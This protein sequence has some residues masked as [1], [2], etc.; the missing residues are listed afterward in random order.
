MSVTGFNPCFLG[1][2]S[3]WPYSFAVWQILLQFQSLF[4]W[5]DLCVTRRWDAYLLSMYCFNP[6][7]LG[8]TSACGSCGTS[9]AERDSRRVSILVFLDRPLRA[10]A[11]RGD[12]LD[13][14]QFQSLFSWIDLCVTKPINGNSSISAGSKVSILVFLDR[15]LRV[16][17]SVLLRTLILGFNPCF[18][19]STSA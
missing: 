10:V 12:V 14:G 18:L 16:F 2:T 17:F 1:S 3:A 11:V 5:I 8:S 9:Q 4:S 15:P 6:C 7:F 13:V 19:G